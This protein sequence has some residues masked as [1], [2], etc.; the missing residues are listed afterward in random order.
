MFLILSRLRVVDGGNLLIADVRQGDEGEYQCIAQNMAGL[1][2][3]KIAKLTVHG[4]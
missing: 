3:S 1:R 4:L 2:E